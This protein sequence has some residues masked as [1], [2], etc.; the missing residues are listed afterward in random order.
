VIEAEPCFGLMLS[1]LDER[2]LVEGTTR[3][4]VIR[5]A[6][7]HQGFAK[8]IDDSAPGL[9]SQPRLLFGIPRH[10]HTWLMMSRHGCEA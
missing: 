3:V 7:V 4:E 6:R 8:L 1:L 5:L 2:G 9:R 10:V